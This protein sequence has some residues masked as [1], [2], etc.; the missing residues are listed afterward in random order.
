MATR[1]AWLKQ[2]EHGS[3]VN[4]RIKGWLTDDQWKVIL[5]RP[6]ENDAFNKPQQRRPNLALE[7]GSSV[8]ERA[9]RKIADT[10]E[11]LVNLMISGSLKGK[12]KAK[13]NSDPKYWFLLDKESLEYKY[14]KLKL[15]EMERLMA[16]P[17][18]EPK[19]KKTP[20]ERASE[21]VRAMLYAR[22]VASIKRRLFR[23]K[24]PGILQLAARARR[25]KKA[26]VGTQTLLSAGTMLK[27]QHSQGSAASM[28][29][30]TSLDQASPAACSNDP[31]EPQSA[32]EVPV[33]GPCMEA[34][35]PA[36]SVESQFTD[37]DIKT[38][39]TAG[40]LAKFVAQVGPE[41]EQFSIDNSADNPD[42]WFL[43][44]RESLAF[45][46]YRAKVYELCP[47]I[48]FSSVEGSA[49]PSQS[50]KFLEG[51]E[52]DEEEQE[53]EE[54]ES[55]EE[56]SQM[57]TEREGG[58]EA[59]G[60]GKTEEPSAAEEGQASSEGAA[61]KSG[62]QASSSAPPQ[63]KRISSKS[64]KVG[65]LPAQK[66]VCH[67]E[68]PQVHEPVRIAYDRPRGYTSYKR[69]KVKDTEFSQKKLTGKNIGFQMLKKMGWQ[70]GIFRMVS[71]LRLHWIHTRCA[72]TSV[73]V[74]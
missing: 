25:V 41:I 5:M 52:R 9:D 46:Y 13:L 54:A 68:E 30:S 63:R 39:A 58:E 10:I 33:A 27:Q 43:Q 70:E 74:E 4:G 48:S 62:S 21:S 55:E 65:M 49:D 37:V 16:T 7:E 22:K 2:S 15:A 69:K 29:G 24:R 26:T 12:E 59:E 67:V 14:Y 35:E 73:L 11:K 72:L 8:L 17:K 42:L 57:E 44:D 31:E 40:K 50:P 47:S 71:I 32:G 19:E 51:D 56:A 20:E 3:T 60:A 53:D 34:P 23:R 64:L 6:S 61:L 28:E 36:P 45:K 38:M 1:G 66:R 18:E